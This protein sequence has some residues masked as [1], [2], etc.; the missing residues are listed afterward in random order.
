MMIALTET[1]AYQI[2]FEYMLSQIMLVWY[3]NRH[4]N[5]AVFLLQHMTFEAR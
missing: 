4:K 3:S 5:V 1:D 2:D